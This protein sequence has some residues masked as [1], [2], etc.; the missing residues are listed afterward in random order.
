MVYALIFE[1]TRNPQFTGWNSSGFSFSKIRNQLT[2]TLFGYLVFSGVLGILISVIG[3][4][5]YL[6][7]VAYDINGNLAYP[8]LVVKENPAV[9]L[10]VGL[11]FAIIS[12]LIIFSSL[13]RLKVSSASHE[14]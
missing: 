7:R 14:N 12:L 4:R 3:I 2:K 1:I 13:R 6:Q 10:S 9:I 5:L 11:I 8:P